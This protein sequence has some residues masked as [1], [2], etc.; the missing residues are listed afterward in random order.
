MHT[1]TSRLNNVYI[2]SLFWTIRLN[3]SEHQQKKSEKWS[4]D[5]YLKTEIFLSSV[6][7]KKVDNYCRQK[8]Q[9]RHTHDI[10]WFLSTDDW[11]R[12]VVENNKKQ[13]KKKKIYF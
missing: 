2:Y 8:N 7:G 11:Q 13:I 5:T 1:H 10:D 12:V 4:S 6:N 9:H 3:H